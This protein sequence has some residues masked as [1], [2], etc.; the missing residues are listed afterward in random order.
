[1]SDK[2]ECRVTVTLPGERA[3]VGRL[4]ARRQEADGQWVFQ[5]A[6]GIPA[7]AV[8][9]IPGEDYSDVPTERAPR[10]WVL[11]A[12]RHDRPDQRAGVLH[13][14]ASCWAA[15]RTLTPIPADQV[16]IFLREGWAIPCEACNPNPGSP[17]PSAR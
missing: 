7:A 3:V 13:T 17:E 5:V 1:M 8:A 11:E 4:L 14:D 15:Q 12:L 16:K 2:K 10:P 9:P 6:L